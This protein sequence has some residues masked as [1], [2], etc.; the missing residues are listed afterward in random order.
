MKR[1]QRVKEILFLTIKKVFDPFYAGGAAEVAF[2]LLLSLVPATILLAQILDVFTLSMDAIKGVMSEY[3]PE[4]VVNVILPLL[5]YKP[6]NT[7]GIFL[8]L[9]ALWSGSRALFSL[10]RISN[11]AYKSPKKHR[12]PIIRYLRERARAV[13]TIVAILVTLIFALY[14][15]IFGEV[16]V[17]LVFSYVNDFLGGTYHFSNVW[18]SVRWII[19][20]VLYLFTV[21]TI[22]YILPTKN[23]EISRM[24]VK[25]FWRTVWNLIKGWW[26]ASKETMDMI[27][28]GSIFAALG[29]LLATWLYSFY[30][31]YI[32][33]M[34]NNFNIMY[35]GLS[36]V[37]MLLIWF[38]VIA[39]VLIIGIQL[40]ASLLE[41]KIKYGNFFN[42]KRGRDGKKN[43]QN[44]ASF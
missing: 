28:P 4:N 40:N 11:Y 35:G 10:M 9:L 32:S 20:F 19:A 25:G 43:D 34:S 36:T 24:I 41:N 21:L 44:S 39:F 8:F 2:F 15:L 18:Y 30:M 14:I 5:N 16:L 26:K 42:K 12:N 22:Y 27:M 33:T 37:V 13:F 6:S 17:K 7:F 1:T 38:Y 31:K 29:M 3:L 23:T